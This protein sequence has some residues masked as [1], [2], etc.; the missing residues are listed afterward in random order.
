MRVAS[1]GH[2]VFAIA[3]IALGVLG[4][5]KGDFE[6]V[7]GGVPANFPG[8]DVLPY[9]CASVALL[10]GVGLLFQRTAAFASRF[11]LVILLLWMLVFKGRFILAAPLEEGTYQSLGENAAIVAAAW[12][13]YAWLA[14]DQRG[15]AAG[16]NGVR[17]ARVLYALAMIAFGFSHFVY[18]N[19]T[20]PLVPAWLPAHVGWAYFTGGAYLAAGVA[21]LFD[22]FARLAAA[23]SALQM[24]LITA[25]VWIP[26]VASG[27]IGAFQ[28]GEFVMSCV[29]TASG[30]VLTDSYRG[31][32]WFA[33]RTAAA[34]G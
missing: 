12:V 1:I 32:R 11:L 31:A 16:D 22:V 10:S 26:L 8:R 3:M 34:A 14:G 30:W 5:I 4:F 20:A 7:W 33:P 18:L 21:I 19:L 27:Q 17:I 29:L 23:L 6:A 9:I 24:G 25:L 2:G 15:F 13:L 28:W